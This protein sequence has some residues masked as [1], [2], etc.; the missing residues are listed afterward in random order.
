MIF[1]S[2][3]DNN[4]Q[5]CYNKYI[6][7][8]KKNELSLSHQTSIWT[9][10]INN[11]LGKNTLCILEL[12]VFFAVLYAI[13]EQ[14]WQVSFENVPRAS[15]VFHTKTAVMPPNALCF[16][17]LLIN[18]PHTR[19]VVHGRCVPTRF[20]ITDWIEKPLEGAVQ[21]FIIIDCLSSNS[22]IRV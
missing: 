1:L 12:N 22:A 7:K 13:F 5:S 17:R 16:K 3:I 11:Y 18:P 21:Q 2:F 14:I 9:G 15:N 10:K 8:N 6:V 4:M 19:L 20:D